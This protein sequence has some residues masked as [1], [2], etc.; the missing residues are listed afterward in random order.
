MSEHEQTSDSAAAD[1]NLTPEASERS[2]LPP[3]R[4][5]NVFA[6]FDDSEKA[7]DLI[8]ALE[9]SG[10][11]GRFVSAIELTDET[12]ADSEPPDQETARREGVE[13]DAAFAHEITIQGAK[14][15]TVGAAL[16]ALSGT[17]VAL[18]IPGLGLAAGAGIL[19]VTAGGAVAGAG[20]GTFAGALS[21]TPASRSWQRALVDL[22]HGEI[23]VGVHTDEQDVFDQAV[24]IMD[25]S[26]PRSLR[27][28][29]H[30]GEQVS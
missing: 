30:E 29:D 17:V 2:E 27:R 12:L 15:G 14:G 11:D 8:L 25:D 23:V 6:R 26:S 13:E 9:R 1:S 28:V 20:V 19:A 10:I 16:G 21:H 7:R 3:L 18:A 5:Y 4:T 24:S 22:E